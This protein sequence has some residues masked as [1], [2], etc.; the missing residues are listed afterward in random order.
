MYIHIYVYVDSHNI[1]IIITNYQNNMYVYPQHLHMYVLLCNSYLLTI[2]DSDKS[3]PK[4]REHIGGE[5]TNGK[6]VYVNK[7]NV[8][9]IHINLYTYI[10]FCL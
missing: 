1:M 4:E 2:A 3:M 8:S 5:S 7:I 6:M 9:Y 10:I